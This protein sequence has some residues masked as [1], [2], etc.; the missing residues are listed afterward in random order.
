VSNQPRIAKLQALLQR[1]QKHAAEPRVETPRVV[2]APQPHA[3]PGP[4]PSKRMPPPLPTRSTRPMMEKAQEK[5]HVETKAW[6]SPMDAVIPGLAGLGAPEP[7]DVSPP[8][9]APMEKEPI[10]VSAAAGV[11]PPK[12]PTIQTRE[13]TPLPPPEPAEVEAI[14]GEYA[15]YREG[16]AAATSATSAGTEAEAEAPMELEE[17]GPADLVEEGESV[18]E[19]HVEPAEPP[20]PAPT[21]EEEIEARMEMES[22]PAPAPVE[23]PPASGR[24]IVAAPNESSRMKVAAPLIEESVAR[25]AR[26]EHEL[27]RTAP[28]APP[29]PPPPSREPSPEPASEPRATSLRSTQRFGHVAPPVS[30]PPEAIE[31]PP[32][33]PIPPIAEPQAAAVEPRPSL[34]PP[35]INEPPPKTPIPVAP[36]P[37]EL[38]EAIVLRA[39]IATPKHVAAFVEASR[40]PVPTTFAALLDDALS[41]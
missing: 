35:P 12:E 21:P 33:T 36:A 6:E 29:L 41:L 2:A 5:P 17:L 7:I 1:I 11:A 30:V 14:S 34:P 40:T 28:A 31:P 26:D 18:V 23:E 38:P 37:E 20:P 24:E 10:A 19:V 25:D 15:V 9:A 39:N 27:E 16:E 13:E 4:P 3:P 22:G 8:P 32:K